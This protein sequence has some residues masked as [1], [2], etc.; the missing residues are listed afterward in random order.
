VKSL[1]KQGHVRGVV[2]LAAS[3]SG[4]PVH[5]YTPLEVKK[6]VVGYGQ[7]EKHQVQM[8]IRAILD[9]PETLPTDASDALA[10]AIC[11]TNFRK[12]EAL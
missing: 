8:M 7:A 11:H 2:L 10:V 1:I 5:E 9:L 3:R 6:S 4:I 12:T